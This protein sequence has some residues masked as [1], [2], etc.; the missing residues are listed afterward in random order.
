LGE[1]DRLWAMAFEVKAKY[2]PFGEDAKL[3]L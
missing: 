2:A 3:G 1:F